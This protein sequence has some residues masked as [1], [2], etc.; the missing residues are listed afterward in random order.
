MRSRITDQVYNF[1]GKPRIEPPGNL[2]NVPSAFREEVEELFRTRQFASRDEEYAA[3]RELQDDFN[4]RPRDEF[5]GLSPAQMQNLIYSP[6][7]SPEAGMRCRYDLT[8]EEASTAESYRNARVF[9]ERLRDEGGTKATTAGNLNRKF[10]RGM[11]DVLEMPEGWHDR[12]L[13]Y[14]KALNEY[15]VRRLN[16]IRL[17]LGMAG[18]VRKYKGRFVISK[19]GESSLAPEKAGDFYYT[20]FCTYFNRFNLAYD[21]SHPEVPEIQS[22]IRYS[23][24]VL[25]KAAQDWTLISDLAG[26]VYAPAATRNI[27]TN[28]YIDFADSILRYRI[29][30]SLE[31]FNLVER[32]PEKGADLS[33]HWGAIE[34]TRITPL[35]HRFLEFPLHARHR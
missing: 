16:S 31:R 15:D 10:V 6:W 20:L 24:Y 19:K 29:L 9:L 35:Y 11:V 21:D 3:L 28:P 7:E 34:Q 8:F 14:H 27:P 5:Q 33:M 4:N 30:A 32:K 17:V 1:A 18:Y 2:E 13:P 26:V 22:T 25:G 12:I 23:L